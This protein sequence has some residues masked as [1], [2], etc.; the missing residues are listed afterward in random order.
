MSLAD[1]QMEFTEVQFMQMATGE[2]VSLSSATHIQDTKA[3]A[4][5]INTMNAS[6]DV[7]GLR[8]LFPAPITESNASEA[9]TNA[10]NKLV[11]RCKRIISAPKA[12]SRIAQVSGHRRARSPLSGEAL[13]ELLDS[14][15]DKLIIE[16]RK[17]V[18]ADSLGVASAVR[19]LLRDELE[20]AWETVFD[21]MQA[22]S[23]AA[24]DLNQVERSLATGTNVG[25]QRSC[26]NSF[27]DKWQINGELRKLL[28]WP[29]LVESLLLNRQLNADI[30]HVSQDPACQCLTTGSDLVFYGMNPD[31][32]ARMAFV[33]Y[34]KCRWP[35]HVFALDPVAQDQNV[36]DQYAMRRELQLAMALALSSGRINAQ[37]ATRFARRLEMD[38]ETVALNRTAVA[39]GHGRD[40]FG[41]RFSPRVQTPEFESNGK[42]LFRDLLLGGP[43]RDELKKQWQLEPGVRECFAV[44]LMPSF[45]THVR[46]DSRGHFSP[47]VCDHLGTGCQ[48]GQGYESV[49]DRKQFERHR[50]TRDCW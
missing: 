36:T 29:V 46:F 8:E 3:F 35:I 13:Y 20:N 14:D 30:R 33:Q 2:A 42:V 11:Q 45:I 21:P 4:N 37:T 19:N 43:N 7:D 47:L 49:P 48:V 5:A 10:M 12:P 22:S 28:C 6:P 23:L 44:V 16:V 1:P 40:T 39:F 32:T 31:L 9:I 15:I 34:V 26:F 18:R 38:M 17:F 24:L 50:H 27:R 25:E 41:W